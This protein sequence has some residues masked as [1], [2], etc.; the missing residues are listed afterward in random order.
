MK[1]AEVVT[2]CCHRARPLAHVPSL[3]PFA[4]KSWGGSSKG[5]TRG[6]DQSPSAAT[7]LPGEPTCCCFRFKIA[8]LK[9]PQPEWVMTWYCLVWGF[10][11]DWN[12]SSGLVYLSPVISKPLWSKESKCS[13]GQRGQ[14]SPIFTGFWSNSF[15]VLIPTRPSSSSVFCELSQRRWEGL[16]SDLHLWW[17][18]QLC[19]AYWPGRLICMRRKGLIFQQ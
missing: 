1:S 12:P 10:R 19:S 9:S 16:H 4:G 3:P 8:L 17:G 11:G 6:C 14:I 13:L 2:G 5:F 18:R 7:P 15:W